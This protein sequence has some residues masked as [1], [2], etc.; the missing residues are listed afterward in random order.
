MKFIKNM[1]MRAKMLTPVGML[2][3]LLLLSCYNSFR[4]VNSMMD[5][6]REISSNYAQKIYLL[7]V[8]AEDF[9][10]LQRIL[11]SHCLADSASSKESL[12]Q[13][14]EELKAEMEDISAQYSVMLEAGTS[15]E[16]SFQNFQK[17][18]ATYIDTYEK[19]IAHSN[20]GKAA[21]AA[22]LANTALLERGGNITL[23]ISDMV[24]DNQEAMD[25]AVKVQNDTYTRSI[26]V[27]VILL[28]I[29]AVLVVAAVLVCWI[30]ISIPIIKINGKLKEIVE[31]IQNRNGD[32]TERLPVRGRDEIGQ[33]AV[34]INTFIET[35]QSI[36]VQITDSTQKLD[37]VVQTVGQK[38][39]S[40]ND[41]A[42][43]ISSVM[44]QLSASMEEVSATASNINANTVSVDNDADMLAEASEN[45]LEYTGAMQRRAEALEHTAEENK[46]NTSDIIVDIIGK[47]EKA[48]QDSK[49]VERVNDLTGEILSISGQTNLLALNA[50][51]EAARAGEAGRGFAVVADEISK[52]ADSSKEAASNIQKIN[53]MVVLAVKELT[54]SADSLVK[55]INENIMPDYDG[56]VQSGRQYNEDA[57][58]VNEIVQQFSQMSASLRQ[59]VAGITDSMRDISSA[60]DE[61]ANGVSTVAINTNDLVKEMGE[62]DTAMEENRQ[63]AGYLTQETE[64]FNKL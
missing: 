23:Q 9:Q 28:V 61:S 48:I 59:L 11:Y 54:D 42:M 20:N 18:F 6:G 57:N 34:N 49:S 10:S 24:A 32:L 63:V 58:H 29:A 62:I 46:R 4:N 7:G 53:G 43:D 47:L 51:I 16:M 14:Y 45:L 21:E 39:S 12:N 26:M 15:E 19:A 35:L 37:E 36:M 1:N 22:L 55:Y 40:V 56:F 25:N 30:E 3:L 33:M 5:A 50:S 31:K 17:F 52:L 44:Q 41:N 60:V 2:A 13:E 38:V 27:A 8:I 64:R